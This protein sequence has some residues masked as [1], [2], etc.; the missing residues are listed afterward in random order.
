MRMLIQRGFTLIEILIGLAIFAFLAMLAAPMYADMLANTEVRN[1]AES[2][3]DGV[4]QAQASAVKFNAP[5][6]FVLTSD[7]WT[8]FMV[9]TVDSDADTGP[10][11]DANVC[12]SAH[13]EPTC[14]RVWT[15]HQGASRASISTTGTVS[16]NAFGQIVPN[17][18]ASATLAQVD[19]TTTAIASPH[20]LRVLIITTAQPTGALK[21]CD[22]N[23]AAS[24]PM[25]CPS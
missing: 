15:F 7:G 5:A 18:D 9:D 1:A 16:F 12:S 17:D 20:N 25:G 24:D 11:Y 10:A 22:T 19:V 21:L 4:R 2:I 13:T 23:Y 8:V 14:A 6:K 3:L